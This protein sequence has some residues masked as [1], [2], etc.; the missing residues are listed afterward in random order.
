M[1]KE[2]NPST[3]LKTEINGDKTEAT[4]EVEQEEL[5]EGPMGK[6]HVEE[7]TIVNAIRAIKK[8]TYPDIVQ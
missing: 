3:G 4:L 7:E 1:K 8:D 5:T 2:R 6:Q